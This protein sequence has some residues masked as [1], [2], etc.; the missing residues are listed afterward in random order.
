MSMIMTLQ[1]NQ[2]QFTIAIALQLTYVSVSSNYYV[3]LQEP[4]RSPERG[5]PAPYFCRGALIRLEDGSLRRVEEMRTEDFVM[6][7]DRIS[8]LALTQCTLLRLDER[9]DKLALTLT[10]D[11]N[12]SQ[13]Y[14]RN[15]CLTRESEMYRAD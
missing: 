4:P 8:D 5:A 3:T 9:G 11:R 2:K 1:L 15:S 13:V 6:S 14:V 10:Y 7:A 12:R